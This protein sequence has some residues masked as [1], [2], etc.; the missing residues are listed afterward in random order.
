VAVCPEISIGSRNRFQV[1]SEASDVS[2]AIDGARAFVAWWAAFD[3][4]APRREESSGTLRGWFG[5][6]ARIDA[7]YAG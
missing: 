3:G 2:A 1:R 5:K 6:M 4:D 7:L